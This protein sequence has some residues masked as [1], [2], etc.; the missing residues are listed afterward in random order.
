MPAKRR[1]LKMDKL[2]SIALTLAVLTVS[3]GQT[4]AV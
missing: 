4:P 3:T 2:I 1:N